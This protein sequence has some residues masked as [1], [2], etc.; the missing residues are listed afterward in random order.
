MKKKKIGRDGIL[1][2]YNINFSKR[3]NFHEYTNDMLVIKSD[4]PL[5]EVH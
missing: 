1:V 4:N 3:R 5:I 2:N